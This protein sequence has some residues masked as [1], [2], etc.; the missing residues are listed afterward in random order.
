MKTSKFLLTLLALIFFSNISNATTTYIG[1]NGGDWNEIN[2]W[3]NGLPDTEGDYNTDHVVIPVNKEVFIPLSSIYYLGID[4][5][6]YGTIITEG[7]VIFY[8]DIDN[9]GT[10]INKH[11]LYVGSTYNS[12]IIKNEGFY[13][14]AFN[15][16]NS[17]TLENTGT[18]LNVQGTIEN[19]G[20]ILNENIFEN[21]S[22]LDNNGNF[23]NTG[24][25]TNTATFNNN[26]GFKN[27]QG[28]FNNSNIFNNSGS[29]SNQSSL[30]NSGMFDNAGTIENGGTVTNTSTFSNNGT[31]GNYNMVQNMNVFE[32]METLNNIGIFQNTSGAV[33]SNDGTLENIGTIRNMGDIANNEV[34]NNMGTTYNIN[35]T[36]NNGDI[37]NCDGAWYGTDPQGNPFMPCDNDLDGGIGGAH[38]SFVGMNI[39]QDFQLDIFPNPAH[40]QMTL[41]FP[42]QTNK[43][44]RISIYNQMGQLVYETATNQN[45]LSIDLDS[46]SQ[47]SSGI[48]NIVVQQN[49]AKISKQVVVKM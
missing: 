47:F 26:N 45:Q 40:Q 23:F 31:F 5:E 4:I 14:S 28:T 42:N 22:Q 41:T 8:G 20:V 38:S 10:L 16:T 39:E 32:N 18:Y 24:T 48:Y 19:T 36:Y 11:F 12:G 3:D 2:N 49:D 37:D 25:F 34:F 9:D 44:T 35:M 21:G 46:S 27:I 33:F 6:N 29:F 30:E 17:G 1:P 13:R 43:D 7:F 15:S